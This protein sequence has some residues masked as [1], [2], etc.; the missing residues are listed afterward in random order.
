MASNVLKRKIIHQP[1]FDL[2]ITCQ[3]RKTDT[4]EHK[5][6]QAIKPLIEIALRRKK[7]R[8]AKYYDAIE[9]IE[10]LDIYDR[11]LCMRAHKITSQALWKIL[12]PILVPEFLSYV[13][14]QNVDQLQ[15][16]TDIEKVD[17]DI[18]LGLEKLEDNV[19]REYL[20]RA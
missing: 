10:R 6:S 15:T 13:S 17:I 11:V 12:L 7:V 4:L 8:D 18:E 5:Q 9:R 20:S 3:D 16:L 19:F 1:G 2:C 14:R